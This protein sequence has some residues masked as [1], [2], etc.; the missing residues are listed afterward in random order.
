MYLHKTR[1]IFHTRYCQT[2]EWLVETVTSGH[3][4][5]VWCWHENATRRHDMLSHVVAS[6]PRGGLSLCKGAVLGGGLHPTQIE[7]LPR[8][9]TDTSTLNTCI[10]S[11]A[12]SHPLCCI[13]PSVTAFSVV[14]DATRIHGHLSPWKKA[15]SQVKP[16]FIEVPT[17]ASV[18]PCK[19]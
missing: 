13:E 7:M 12:A 8:C 4:F 10:D 6:L 2:K 14:L 3:A 5:G 17:A 15:I 18:K 9:P 16:C 11:L 19:D 1:K